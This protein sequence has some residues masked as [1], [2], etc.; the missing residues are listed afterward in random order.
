MRLQAGLEERLLE[1]QFVNDARACRDD[2]AFR[3]FVQTY[4]THVVT[5]GEIGGELLI[6]M[7]L[8]VER[9]EQSLVSGAKLQTTVAAEIEGIPVNA[10]ADFDARNEKLDKSYRSCSSRKILKTGGDV[11]ARTLQEWR[12]SLK[13]ARLPEGRLQ[14]LPPMADG[15]LQPMLVTHEPDSLAFSVTRLQPISELLRRIDKDAAKRLDAMIA[16]FVADNRIDSKIRQFD[17]LVGGGGALHTVKPGGSYHCGAWALATTGVKFGL[18]AAPGVH[19]EV[20]VW[21]PLCKEQTVPLWAGETHDA[22]GFYGVGN[23]WV[24]LDCNDA[25]ASLKLHV[26]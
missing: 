17:P 20:R 6:A 15:P 5:E 19:A 22:S 25:A 23:L 3:D 26:W 16:K 2:E 18:K 13:D 4:G 21:H 24:Y 8:N 12:D 9:M 11:T 1:E 10:S 14:A 7:E